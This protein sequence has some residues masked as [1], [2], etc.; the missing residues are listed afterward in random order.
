MPTLADPTPAAIA[1]D[2][3]W[4]P[5]I[6]DRARRAV[7][8]QRIARTTLGEPGF[9]ADRIPA[10][11]SDACWVSFDDVAAMQP[12]IGPLHFIFHTAFCRSTLLV[13]ALNHPGV[14]AGLAEPRIIVALNNA[15]EDR[16]RLARPLLDL[17]SRTGEG[18]QAVFVKP[19]NHA[20]A[21]VPLLMDTRP[22]AK[23][24][25]MTNPLP[26]FLNAVTRK[27][28]MGRRW[29]RQLFAE[30]QGYAGMDFGMPPAEVFAMTDMQAAGLAWFLN[31]RFLTQLADR[32]GDRVRV[33][34]GD[35]F[36]TARAQTIRALAAF[37]G[38]AASDAQIEAVTT[39]PA[40]TTHAKLGGNF[41]T[42]DTADTKRTLSAVGE[43]EVAQVAL[44]VGM[45]A[46]QAGLE[47]PVRQTLF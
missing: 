33:L 18:E 9:L 5:H 19:T 47:V 11:P 36:D 28:L 35:C 46:E 6:I 26:S 34:D 37:T 8:F 41:A 14:S 21:V 31:Q 17:L 24:V 3:A 10:K 22:D 4:I 45:I 23:A 20:N 1:A 29:G 30:M 12:A 42:K 2:P 27:G 38:L 32:Y 13:R 15:G 7:Q 16:P 44:W 43:E 40:F 25:L 39:G